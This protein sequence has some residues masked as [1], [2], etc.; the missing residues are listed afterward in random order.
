MLK[1][2]YHAENL[3]QTVSNPYGLDEPEFEDEPIDYGYA[4]AYLPRWKDFE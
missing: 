4:D 1:C 2:D 3:R